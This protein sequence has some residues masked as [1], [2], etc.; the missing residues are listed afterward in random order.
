MRLLAPLCVALTLAGPLAA[1]EAG[2][3]TV[4]GEGHVEAVPDMATLSLGVSHEAKSAEEAM[5]R[6]SADLAAVLER[7]RAAG[8]AERDLQTQGLDLAPVWSSY[9]SGS[10]RR[11]TGFRATNMLSVRLRGLD[12]LGE[13]LDLVIGDGANTFRGLSLG[14]QEPLPFRDAARRAAVADARRKAALYS[15]AA[16]LTLGP[17]LSISEGAAEPPRPVRMDAAVASDDGLPVAPGEVCVSALVT[18]VFEIDE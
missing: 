12:T 6:V 16:G 11:I 18:M 3:L 5:A 4:T 14:L 2:R 13:T 17:V 7:L 10:D 8:V 1:A 15:E 9:G